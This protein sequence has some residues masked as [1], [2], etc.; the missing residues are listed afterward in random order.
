MAKSGIAQSKSLSTDQKAQASGVLDVLG[1][2]AQQ[3]AWFD[4]AK[5][6]QAIGVAVTTARKLG[7]KNPDQ[8]RTMDFDTAM[9]KYSTGF[10]GAK[11][12]L[13]I[14]GLSVDDTL[15]S[16]RLTPVSSSNGHAVVKV[17]YILLGKPLSTQSKMVQQDGRWYAEDM[18]ENVRQ[19]HRQLIEQ[20]AQASSGA[21]AAPG[22][23]A[24]KD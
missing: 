9:V 2:W 18:L 4:P 1:P 10:A 22:T 12:L 24:A 11:Q 17:D 5:A 13:A 16:V 23:A 8:L 21:P 6:R 14:Y 15:H 3:A 20:A 19:S 7:L